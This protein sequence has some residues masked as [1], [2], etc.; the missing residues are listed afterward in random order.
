MNLDISFIAMDKV[1]PN[2]WNPNVQN[3]QQFKAEVESIAANGFLAPIL[4]RELN[5]TF[6]IIDGEHRLKALKAIKERNLEG[7]RNVPDLVK[8]GTIPAIVIDVDDANAK[9]LT[10]IMNETRGR[11]DFAKLGALLAEIKIELPDEIGI[12]MPYTETQLNELMEMSA[13]NW[14]ALDLPP[15]EQEFEIESEGGEFKISAT[16]DSDTGI[17]W[18]Q[19]LA[20]NKK[21][22]PNDAKL[23][24]GALITKL[25]AKSE[26]L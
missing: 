16:L 22:L 11:A 14:E 4:V 9:K 18:K 3:E 5:D 25:I 26:T 13:F 17:K 15:V 8:N 2:P 6:Q 7:K 21:E 24:A 20:E 23:A 10:I 19:M 12:G 1:E